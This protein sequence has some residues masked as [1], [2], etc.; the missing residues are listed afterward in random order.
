MWPVRLSANRAPHRLA[1]ASRRGAPAS[2]AALGL[3]AKGDDFLI[4]SQTAFNLS[5]GESQ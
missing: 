1:T 4:L 5:Q 3:R 2:L